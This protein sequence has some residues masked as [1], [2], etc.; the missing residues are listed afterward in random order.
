MTLQTE[1]KTLQSRYIQISYDKIL[2][3]RSF[4]DSFGDVRAEELGLETVVYIGDPPDTKIFLIVKALN[5]NC[6]ANVAAF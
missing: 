3:R 6:C 5:P 4:G 2:A 1:K